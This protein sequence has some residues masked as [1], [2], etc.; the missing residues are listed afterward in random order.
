MLPELSERPG[1]G[2]SVMEQ[3]QPLS[4]ALTP[5]GQCLVLPGCSW[6]RSRAGG[7]TSRAQST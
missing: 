7:G 6:Y 2:L 1:G 5:A 4:L 3:P